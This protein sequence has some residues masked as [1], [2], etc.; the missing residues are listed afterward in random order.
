LGS[1]RRQI[2]E[3]LASD[4]A[5]KGEP[6]TTIKKSGVSRTPHGPRK[7]TRGGVKIKHIPGRSRRL[8]EKILPARSKERRGLWGSL[9]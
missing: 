3:A 1:E 8:A 7:R 6:A 2:S 9:R 4:I 5:R